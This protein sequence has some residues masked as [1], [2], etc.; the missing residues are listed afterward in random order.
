[1]VIL[2]LGEERRDDIAAH[3]EAAARLA[4]EVTAQFPPPVELEFEKVFNPY[5]LLEKK[6][7][8][9]YMYASSPTQ[10]DYVDVK[11]LS[12]VRRDTTPLVRKVCERVL[13]CLL[14]DRDVQ[15]ALDI[16]RQAVL[17]LLDGR[18]EWAD[19]TLSK[20]LRGS[21]T[22]TAQPHLH[23]ARLIKQRT[24]ES[25]ASGTRVPYVFVV[26]T[27]ASVVGPRSLQAEDPTY[28]REHGDSI[29]ALYYI[30][31]HLR[32]PLVDLL[33]VVSDD[34]H[35]LIFGDATIARRM[36]E[37]RRAA[38][39]VVQGVR[40]EQKR[41]KFVASNHLQPITNFFKRL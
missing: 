30:E 4:R 31:H 8:A 13:D 35:T 17:D 23:V 16:G 28:A 25:I 11:G 40:R 36:D 24:G 37:L 26:R 21:Y 22:N 19:V 3:F 1:M 6:K 39:G 12:T 10:P 34:P 18:F 20:T 2:N 38:K 27:D 15:K 5:L 14:K 32:N 33:K 29:D 7:Y 9:G 41:Q